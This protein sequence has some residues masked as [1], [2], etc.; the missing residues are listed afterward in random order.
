MFATETCGKWKL[1]S[2]WIYYFS[3]N[4]FFDVQWLCSHDSIH[5]AGLHPADSLGQVTRLVVDCPRISGGRGEEI[6]QI[7]YFVNAFQVL[8]L[9]FSWLIH[10]E[11]FFVFLINFE[12]SASFCSY[13]LHYYNHDDIFCT[14]LI[15]LVKMSIHCDIFWVIL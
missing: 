12:S 10:S 14:F 15:I 3:R 5:R 1:S 9:Y 2:I 8:Y 13:L 7:F 4:V 11:I 6:R